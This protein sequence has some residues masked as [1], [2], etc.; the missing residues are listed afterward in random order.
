MKLNKLNK[1]ILLLK[2]YITLIFII[3]L[4]F[5]QTKSQD[6][7]FSQQFSNLPRL[8]PAF[9]GISRCGNFTLNYRNQS[10]SIKNAH[11][12]YSATYQQFVYGIHSGFALSYFKNNVGNNAFVQN[13][14]DFIYAFHFKAFQKTFASLALQTSFFTNKVSNVG[15]IYSD[16]IY[17][18]TGI[19]NQTS[20]STINQKYKILDF[21][22]GLIFY[23]DIYYYGLAI[24]HLGKINLSQLFYVYP[25]KYTFLLGAKFEVD[26]SK[27]L[28]T[29]FY[30]SPNILFVQQSE[31]QEINLG[32]YFYK[33]IFTL[34]IWTRMSLIPYI[35]NDAV[36]FILG[37]N[38]NK[39]KIG[40]S[41]DFATSKLFLKSFGI[42]EISLN[43]KINCS[44]KIK[45]KNTISCPSF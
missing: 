20:E 11:N 3:L 39:L 38:F 13:N 40:Y 28:R 44:E 10:P 21:S 8:N 41:Y 34:G 29:D 43:F 16:M 30:F 18:E 6:I 2:R 45:G 42:H 37:I 5:L 24:H 31:F 25:I 1:T 36:I 7:H 27:N 26:K 14:F 9:A 33:D 17:L 4:S 32:I 19:T 12:T 23:N 15:Q 35:G 22:T